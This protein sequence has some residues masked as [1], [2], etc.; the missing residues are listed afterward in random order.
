M[1]TLFSRARLQSR[2]VLA[3]YVDTHTHIA[4]ARCYCN[5]CEEKRAK[6]P[7]ASNFSRRCYVSDWSIFAE[8]II[9]VQSRIASAVWRHRRRR[10]RCHVS[11]SYSSFLLL[12]NYAYI[13]CRY[14]DNTT[15]N[16]S[17]Y[18]KWMGLRDV[19]GSQKYAQT[20]TH[21][22]ARP[23]ESA[24]ERADGLARTLSSDEHTINPTWKWGTY[25]PAT[26]DI[27]LTSRILTLSPPM[28]TTTTTAEK[29]A[30]AKGR[31]KNCTQRIQMNNNVYA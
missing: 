11:L 5:S 15:Q 24:N 6:I 30:E 7:N 21:D 27:G 25:A 22:H 4:D 28:S 12:L 3:T 18:T 13:F 19:L 17:V 14:S 29:M 8:C 1:W 20:H 10:H 16:T 31:K 26:H 9:V 23:R 2:P